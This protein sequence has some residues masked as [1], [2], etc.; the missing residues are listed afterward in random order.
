M[1]KRI[2]L[3]MAIVMAFSISANAA[4]R[5]TVERIK[6]S[7]GSLT[8]SMTGATTAYSKSF[9]LRGSDVANSIGIFFQQDSATADTAYYLEQSYT[10]PTTEGSADTNFVVTHTL[11]ASTSGSTLHIATIDSVVG[12]FARV[13]VVTAN[14]T[15]L[16]T[17]V[18][19]LRVTK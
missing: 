18:S 1:I 3:T 12:L 17:V 4:D 2:I 5:R 11:D 8:I 16:E 7:D 13:K 19:T 15:P 10:T 6:A 9:P 14:S